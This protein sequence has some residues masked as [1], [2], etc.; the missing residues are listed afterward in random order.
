M[1]QKEFETV[2]WL[3]IKERYDQYINSVALKYFNNQC[4]NYLNEVFIKA[5]KSSLSLRYS[6]Q[7]FQ[8]TLRKFNTGRNAFSFIDSTL[9]NKIFKE[10]K[11]T[12]YIN[13][14]IIVFIIVNTITVFIFLM[15]STLSF[16]L[17]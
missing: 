14:F 1:S 4:I 5:P 7:K 16:V 2:N 13:A 11:R 15:L 9:W 17:I 12:T 10:T 3:L 6:Y 8:Q